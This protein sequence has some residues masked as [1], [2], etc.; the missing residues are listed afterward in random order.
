MALAGH[1][2]PHG[3]GRIADAERDILRRRAVPIVDTLQ[4][5]EKSAAVAA[6]MADGIAALQIGGMRGGGLG[7]ARAPCHRRQPVGAAQ[8]VHM[9]QKL[10]LP[11]IHRGRIGNTAKKWQKQR[12]HAEMKSDGILNTRKICPISEPQHHQTRLGEQ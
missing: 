7:Q 10:T 8:G 5:H 9:G 6:I 1:P 3:L 12:D 11:D 2:Q 4:S